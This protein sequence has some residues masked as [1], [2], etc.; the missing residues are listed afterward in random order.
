MS[1][2]ETTTT[3]T[4]RRLLTNDGFLTNRRVTCSGGR[5]VAIDPCDGPSSEFELVAPG[6]VDLQVNGIGRVDVAGADGR[7]W[8]DLDEALLDQGVTSWLP[9]VV[10]APL[11]R[12]SSILGRIKRAALRTGGSRPAI[13]GAHLEGPFLGGAPGAHRKEFIRSAHDNGGLEWLTSVVRLMTVAPEIEAAPQVIASL[14]ARGIVVSLGH[15][16]ATPA[17]FE[18]AVAAGASLVTHLFNGMP[19]FHHRN[20]GPV[21]S[22][23]TEDRVATSLIADGHHVSWQGI[24]I[25]FRCKPRGKTVLVTDAVAAISGRAGDIGLTLVDGV[26][27]L[28][29]GTLAGSTLTMDEAVRKAVT[30]AGVEL[31]VALEAASVNP[32]RIVRAHDRGLIAPGRR[33]DLVALDDRLEVGAVWVAGRRVR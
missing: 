10:T 3:I 14:I 1:G 33:A 22:A 32:A 28:A 11:H 13:L 15:T 29:D 30:H 5:I 7:D 16:A 21:G 17:Q 26:P 20:P 12:Y 6:F 18:Q 27:R 25:A 24:D 8:T 2:D 19:P 9:T 31:E 4:A 23:L